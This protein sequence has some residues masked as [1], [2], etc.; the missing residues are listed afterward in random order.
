MHPLHDHIA[1]QL[2]ERL[3]ARKIVVLY[4]EHREFAPFIAE[5][6]QSAPAREN[7][8]TTTATLDEVVVGAEAQRI[9]PVLLTEYAGSLF[10]LRALAEPHFATSVPVPLLVYLPGCARDRRGSVLMEL[11]KAGTVWEPRLEQLGRSALLHKYTL[12]VVDEMLSPGRR[13]TYEDLARALAGAAGAEPPSIL[14]TI[15]HDMTGNDALLAAFLADDSRDAQIDDKDAVPELRKLVRA[16]TGLD[17]P[18]GAPLAKLR[19]ILLRYVL[20]GEFRSDLGCAPPPSLAAVPAV[21][22]KTEE[23]AVRA[24]AQ[25]LRGAFAAAYTALADRVEQELGLGQEKLPAAAIGAIDTFRFEERAL[26]HHAGDLIAAARYDEALAIVAERDRSYW[27]DRDIARKA[28]WEAARRMAELGRLAAAVQTALGPF[29]GKPPEDWLAAYTQAP[30]DAGAPAWYRLD[31]A[32]RRLEAWLANLDEEPAEKPLGKVRRAYEDACHALAT[33]FARP[34]PR[35]DSPSPVPSTRRA[36]MPISSPR[37][38]P[39]RLLPRGRHALRDGRRA[40][41]TLALHLRGLPAPCG[42]SAACTI[43]PVG[44]AALL[45]GRLGELS[46]VEQDGTLG[47]R[48]DDTFLPNLAARKKLAAARVPKLVDLTLDDLLT[49]SPSKLGKK[50]EGAQ[51]VVV[52]SQEIDEVG[53]T[54]STLQARRAMDLALDNLS[55]ALKKLANAGI[56]QAVITADHGHLFFA[57]DRDESMRT[58]PPG[59]HTVDLHRRCWIG[60]GGSNPSGSVRVSA[61]SLGYASDLDL[62]F[63]SA[64]GVF[65]AGGDL[66]YH[67]GGTSLQELIIPVLTVRTRARESLRPPPAQPIA[68]GNAPERISNRV[69]SITLTFGDKQMLLGAESLTVR[70]SL[71]SAGKQVGKVGMALDAELNRA[72]GCVTLRPNTPATVAFQLTDESVPSLRIV[73]QDPATDAELYRSPHDI[74]IQ[75]GV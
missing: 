61:T 52:R 26:L 16:H 57:S 8:D 39:R 9:A 46:V 34:S 4:D 72:T 32:H 67:H 71:V 65:R 51:V 29:A 38:P 62:V 21:P 70:P 64:S 45:P 27:L 69:V 19:A 60:R 20:A 41:R 43:T 58:D 48:I 12:G 11:E 63:P 42:C 25:R 28:Q 66:A 40:C 30:P 68:V 59:G 37:A 35:P 33:G 22:S 24:V 47:A 5:I 17:L 36:C 2:A 15:F 1:A 7:H 44:M 23:T 73:V 53:E 56:E 6:R 13:I 31:Q 74:P 49:L 14:K 54:G 50:L 18:D 3:K 75:L 10:E 55:R